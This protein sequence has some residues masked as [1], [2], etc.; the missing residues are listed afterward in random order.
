MD[1][2]VACLCLRG[3]ATA[4]ILIA[5]IG[6]GSA[7]DPHGMYGVGHDMLHHWYETLRQPGNGASCC[8]NMDCRPTRS[9]VVNGGVEVELDGEWTP[10]PQNKIL[11]VPSPDLQSHV[12]AP[13]ASSVFP[14]GHIYCVVLGAG[15]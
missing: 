14:K 8:N 11:N 10:V 6:P 5:G 1:F 12:C 3:L 13:R 15:S 4:G 9:R 7:Q 2:R